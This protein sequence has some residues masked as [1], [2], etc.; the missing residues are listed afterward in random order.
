M[1]RAARSPRRHSSVTA[2]CATAAVLVGLVPS[3]VALAGVR[4]VLL[5]FVLGLVAAIGVTSTRHLCA[6]M[7]K[8]KGKHSRGTQYSHYLSARTPTG[9]R[10]ID[11]HDLASVRAR[12][13]VGRA[14]PPLDFVIARD[15]RGVCIAFSAKPDLRIIR[16]AL[17]EMTQRSPAPA[18]RVSRLARAVLGTQPLPGIV[19]VLWALSSVEVPIVVAFVFIIPALLLSR[20]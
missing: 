6:A 8:Q 16:E 2:V 19:S 11:L 17:A 18:V 20:R 15:R 13:L 14:W 1:V 4:V 7:R 5:A 9:Y 12:R 3:L 10:T